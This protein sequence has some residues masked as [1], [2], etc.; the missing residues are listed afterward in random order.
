MPKPKNTRHTPAIPD[1]SSGLKE[2]LTIMDADELMEESLEI[3][4]WLALADCA[5]EVPKKAKAQ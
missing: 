1:A 4:R 5:L 3:V 2:S